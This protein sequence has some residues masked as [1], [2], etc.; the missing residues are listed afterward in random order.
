MYGGIVSALV[1]RERTGNGC[2]VDVA[3]F[4]AALPSLLSSLAVA[5]GTPDET[6]TRTG[7]RHGGLAEAPYN[8]YPDAGRLR[9]DHLRDRSISGTRW[10]S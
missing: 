8:V 9:R 10:P 6:P 5:L 3:M 2:P 4:D 7:N 1:Q